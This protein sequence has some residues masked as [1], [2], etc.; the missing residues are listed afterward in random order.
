MEEQKGAAKDHPEPMALEQT[1]AAVDEKDHMVVVSQ[2]VN[3][4]HD[5]NLCK[6]IIVVKCVKFVFAG[7]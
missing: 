1:E 4:I 5:P 3:F 6:L 7:G 2:F